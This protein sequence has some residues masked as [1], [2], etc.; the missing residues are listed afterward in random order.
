MSLGAYSKPSYQGLLVYYCVSYWMGGGYAEHSK[1]HQHI[2]Q[3]GMD[4]LPLI[5]VLS[6]RNEV[7]EIQEEAQSP[8]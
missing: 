7:A 1:Q 5:K 8:Q 6:T 2:N 3:P 4:V